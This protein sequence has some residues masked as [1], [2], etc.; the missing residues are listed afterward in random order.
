[1]RR[2]LAADLDAAL[3]RLADQRDGFLTGDVADMILT[4]GFLRQS[5]IAFDLLVFAGAADAGE[6]KFLRLAARMDA[7]TL[8]DQASSSQCATIRQ[9]LRLAASIAWRI[10]ASSCTP[11]PLVGEAH[12]PAEASVDRIAL[13]DALLPLSDGGIGNDLDFCVVADPVLLHL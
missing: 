4:A 6:A 12:S 9:L 7:G 10:I 8:G 3:F 5:E 1:M 2:D 13:T 11:L